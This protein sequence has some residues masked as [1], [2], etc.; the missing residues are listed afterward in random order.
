MPA[1]DASTVLLLSDEADALSDVLQAIHLEGRDVSRIA[2]ADAARY[3]ETCARRVV[4]LVERGGL[5]ITLPNRDV[6]V[7]GG[8]LALLPR[9]LEHTLRTT[10][11]TVWIAGTFQV[12]E[13]I[14][15]PMLRVLPDAI[16]ID[17]GE[18]THPW[19]DVAR[20]LIVSELVAPNPGGRVMVSRLLD[21]LFV[22][23]L[24]VW[25]AQEP[26]TPQGLLTATL[27]PHIARALTAIHRDP[28]HPWSVP[29]L[30]RRAQ[31]SRSAFAERFTRLTGMSPGRYA[32]QRRLAYAEQL[33]LA[34]DRPLGRIAADIG[35]E[36]EAA[37]SRAFS[38]AFGESPRARRGRASTSS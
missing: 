15:G 33:V 16:V 3:V 1:A 34:G 17:A 9:G 32:S 7:A 2:V 4:Y 23:T 21:L 28:G 18:L 25:A 27:D 6:L 10:G 30:A 14:A 5:R 35:Y 8:G 20:S 24:R 26:A 31:L 13:Q 38:Q 22:R 11:E 36:S 29:E 12:E 19:L 37:F